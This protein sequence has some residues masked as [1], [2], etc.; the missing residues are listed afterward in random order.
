MVLIRITELRIEPA[1]LNMR[2]RRPKPNDI[3]IGFERDAKLPGEIS[4]DLAALPGNFFGQDF[5]R[6]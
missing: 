4:V 1:S 6:H 3:A 5:H 2:Q